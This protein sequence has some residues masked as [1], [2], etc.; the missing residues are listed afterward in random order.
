MIK[1]QQRFQFTLKGVRREAYSGMT[2]HTLVLTVDRFS[3]V[4]NSIHSKVSIVHL[5]AISSLLSYCHIC[6]Q[7]TVISM[8]NHLP[9]VQQC[10]QISTRINS[11]MYTR[12]SMFVSFETSTTRPVS[13]Q[14]LLVLSNIQHKGPFK[15]GQ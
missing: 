12:T 10:I 14:G 11:S 6:I 2:V 9:L 7:T 13:T 5:R 8:P 4:C 1:S 15:F 3:H